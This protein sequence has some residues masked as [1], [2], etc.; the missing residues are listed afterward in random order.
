MATINGYT[1]IC[2]M[3]FRSTHFTEI[4]PI[5][6]IDLQNQ[7]VSVYSLKRIDYKYQQCLQTLL[8]KKHPTVK[9]VRDLIEKW[10][11]SKTSEWNLRLIKL[12]YEIDTSI[13]NNE[14][15]Y[16]LTSADEICWKL[17]FPIKIYVD[18]TDKLK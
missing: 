13:K 16:F 4:Y 12:K 14:N 18:V 5:K 11:F 6:N 15:F 1:L 2:V 3:E 10:Y 7:E 9:D 8:K 17:M